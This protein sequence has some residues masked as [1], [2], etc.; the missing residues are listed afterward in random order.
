MNYSEVVGRLYMIIII[1]FIV[2]E[3][4][5]SAIITGESISQSSTKVERVTQR[6]K[7]KERKG[8]WVYMPIQSQKHQTDSSSTIIIPVVVVVVILRK[9]Q[10]IT[11]AI[12]KQ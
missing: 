6:K 4:E 10:T 3:H 2:R 1:C 7:E 5:Y 9:L 8:M 11:F 12:V